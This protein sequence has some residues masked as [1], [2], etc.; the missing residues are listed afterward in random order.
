LEDRQAGLTSGRRSPPGPDGVNR[1]GGGPERDHMP[2]T[3][4][5]DPE[6]EV[7]RFN[8]EGGTD[9]PPVLMHGFGLA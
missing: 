4:E 3:R 1:R 7:T 8:W 2:T 6:S 5:V 9:R